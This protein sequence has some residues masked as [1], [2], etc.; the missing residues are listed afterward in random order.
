MRFFFSI[1]GID[2]IIGSAINLGDTSM[3]S[4]LIAASLLSLFAA[5]SASAQAVEFTIVNKTK[6][7]VNAFYTSPVGVKS[8]EDDV[9]GDQALGPDESI[10]ITIEDGRRVCKYDLRFEFQGDD[11][12]DLED[13]QDICELGEYTITE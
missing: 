3:K 6:S 7:V 1:F 5:S 2:D 11:L 4:T 10:T 12:E 13:T 8:W 9:F